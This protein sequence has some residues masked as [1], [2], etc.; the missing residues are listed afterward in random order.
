MQSNASAVPATGACPK[1]LRLHREHMATSRR[2]LVVWSTHLFSCQL[3]GDLSLPGSTQVFS[4][5][6]RLGLGFG[7][8]GFFF[9]EERSEGEAQL[10]CYVV[11]LC[12]SV[13]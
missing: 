2:E 8:V 1:H 13:V 6:F 11:A 5:V 3:S 4:E 10:C 9:W 12:V 7:F